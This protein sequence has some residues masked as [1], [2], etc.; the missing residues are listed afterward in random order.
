MAVEQIKEAQKVVTNEV[1]E[2]EYQL[3]CPICHELYKKP[4]YLTCY[5]S[6]CE[7]CLEKLVVQSNITQLSGV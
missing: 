1:T 2:L 6:Y 4:K 7:E 3:T 5:H